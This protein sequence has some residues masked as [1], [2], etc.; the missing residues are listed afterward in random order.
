[1]RLE[2][3]LLY[4]PVVV[5]ALIAV[6]PV[7]YLIFGSLWTSEPGFP[8]TLTLQNFVAVFSDPSIWATL[9]NSA[10]YSMG[11]A[12][13]A[14]GLA[15]LL[16]I[17][18]VK[19]DAPL[20]KIV[21][22]SLLVAL[23]LPWMVEDMSWTYLLA[24]RT[25]LYNL[26]LSAIPGTGDSLLN[27]YSL[28]GMIWVMGLSLTPLAYLVISPSLSFV[29]SSLEEMA[30][31]S[32]AGIRRTF[33]SVDLPLVLPAALSAALL[34]FVIALEAFDV[35]AII[36]IPG[37][38]SVL[39]TAIYRAVQGQIPPDYNLASALGIVLVFITLSAMLLYSRTVRLSSKYQSLTGR[40]GRPRT[41]AIGKWRWLVGA[42]FLLYLFVYPVPVIG[43]LV[44][45]SLHVYWNP[46][47]LPPLT[48]SNYAQLL[49][50]PEIAQGAL[51]SLAVSLIA[52]GAA[53]F[54]AAFL[55]YSVIRQRSAASRFFEVLAFLPFAFPTVVLAVGLLWALAYS[56]IPIYG[57]IWAL[58]LAYTVRYVPIA[59]RFLTGPLLQVGRELEEMSRICGANVV[60]S[61]RR[62]LLPI[63]R[64]A[65]LSAG[66]YVFIVSI[67]D[68]G[69]AI[70]LVSGSSVLFSAALYTIW[71]SGEV[72]QAVAGGALYVFVLAGVLTLFAGALKVNL[73]TVL[74][75]ETRSEV[76]V[77]GLAISGKSRQDSN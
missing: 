65:L 20:R 42:G 18:V 37:R 77:A 44:F 72:L 64:P 31:I 36:G 45:V 50:F 55:A 51:N 53:S 70:M 5:A 22:Y 15:L 30:H 12:L 9:A 8:G 68:L 66:I 57:T 19:T 48:L 47:H 41:F 25:G 67:K 49:G 74:G 14:T 63:L 21:S 28:W 33:R 2:R 26:A 3:L 6:V 4:L 17:A 58:V 38:V 75:G 35:G 69:A 23:A 43:T 32:G 24:P 54:L 34:A 10:G 13:F 27:I 11:S 46:L 29:D 52:A 76:A 61:F 60:Q 16:A 62:I 73:F 40:G 1:M 59:S 39:T 7:G 56:P 71:S